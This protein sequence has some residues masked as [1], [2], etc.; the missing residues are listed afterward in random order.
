MIQ[1]K[2]KIKPQ[3]LYPKNHRTNFPI[4]TPAVLSP[5]STPVSLRAAKAEIVIVIFWSGN[6]KSALSS[7]IV[8]SSVFDLE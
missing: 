6:Y 1:K 5:H 3:Y 2:H 4:A 7:G 8:T